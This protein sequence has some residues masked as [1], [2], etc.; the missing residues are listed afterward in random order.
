[1]SNHNARFARQ[2]LLCWA[3][4]MGVFI[5]GAI[6]PILGWLSLVAFIALIVPRFWR[7]SI[8]HKTDVMLK[9]RQD[10]IENQIAWGKIDHTLTQRAVR[11]MHERGELP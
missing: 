11:H 4:F 5:M 6:A 7:A 2:A 8:N 9:R 3:A 10:E 1:M